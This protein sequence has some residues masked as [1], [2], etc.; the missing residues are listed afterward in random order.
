VGRRWGL[1]SEDDSALLLR[2]AG[3]PSAMLRRQV[4][5]ACDHQAT[6]AIRNALFAME[7]DKRRHFGTQ[8][9]STTLPILPRPSM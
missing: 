6:A 9:T 2:G 5:Q 4:E 8:G 3:S 1:L 7:A